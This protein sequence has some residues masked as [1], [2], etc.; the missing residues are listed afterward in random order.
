MPTPLRFDSSVF[1]ESDAEEIWRDGLSAMYEIERPTLSPFRASIDSW[2]LGTMLL[3]R[4]FVQDEVSFQRTKRKIAT[5]GIDHYLIHCLLDGTLTSTFGR[6]EQ[7][8]ALGSVAVRDLAVENTGFTRDAPILT[9]IIPRQALD[10]RME[11]DMRIHGV[12]WSATD[13]IGQLVAAHMRSLADV[14]TS[15]D[16][17]ESGIAADGTLDFLAACLIRKAER[18]VVTG[19]PRLAPVLRAQALTFVEQHLSDPGLSPLSVC[20]ALGVSRTTLY[21]L[22]EPIG[23][24]AGYVRMRRLDEAMRRL[25]SPAHS[26]ELVA[27]IA[28][29]VGFVSESSFHRAFKDRFGCTPSEARFDEA[30]QL[31]RKTVKHHGIVAETKAQIRTLRTQIRTLHA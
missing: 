18:P 25:A 17:Q 8:V 23:G 5:S 3:T 16:S 4:H 7:R 24:V 9:L 27:T 14:A 1:R 26:R 28:C 20:Y 30:N 29:A 21:E 10:R 22:F 19:D 31:R 11:P 2:N 12:T 6:G 15:M 13:P